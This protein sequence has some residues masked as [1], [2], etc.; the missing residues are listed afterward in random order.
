MS[1]AYCSNKLSA[2]VLSKNEENSNFTIIFYFIYLFILFILFIYLFII[3]IILRLFSY[4]LVFRVR[5]VSK[6][7]TVQIG[8]GKLI[9]THIH[10][11]STLQSQAFSD[12]PFKL[13]LFNIFAEETKSTYGSVCDIIIIVNIRELKQRRR[14]RQRERQK[15]I[16]LN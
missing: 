8:L 12:I 15:E 13:A 4:E 9:S 2:W 7:E 3:F 6:K 5:A 16:G 1:Q 14:R 10:M 11:L